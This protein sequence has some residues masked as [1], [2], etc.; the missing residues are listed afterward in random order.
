M[1]IGSGLIYT[2]Q[3]TTGAGKWIGYQV[4][5][6]LGM[7]LCFQTPNLATQTCLP[8]HDVPIGMALMFFGQLLGAAVF[9]SVGENVLSNQLVA[10]LS[11][12]PGFNPGL[13]ASGGL[14][15]VLDSIP[16]NRQSTVLMA[17]NESL[18]RVFM[19]GLIL[20]C[21]ATLGFWVMEWRNILQ[22]AL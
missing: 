12:L 18:Q 5:Y 7:G 19:V 13:V 6:G 1:S 14:T 11:S 9:V 15:S 21:L 8:R 22:K 4:I 3:T 17:Y 2:F 16:P 20:S 10:R